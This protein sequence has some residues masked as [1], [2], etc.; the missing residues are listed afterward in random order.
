MDS[1]KN[2]AGRSVLITGASTG[3]GAC[4]AVALAARGARVTVAAR[5]RPELEETV[6][7]CVAAGGEAQAVPADV[8]DAASCRTLV[9]AAVSRFGG[10]DALVNN[11]GISMWA[12][13]DEVTDLSIY[14]KLMRVN[15]LGAVYMTHHALPHLKQSRGLIVAVS[16]LTGKTGVPTRTGY[17][18]SKHALQGFF[19][20]L[21]IELAPSGVDVLVV[22]PGF[23]ATDVRARA[24][25]A[26]GRPLGQSLRDETRATMPL[27]E[28]VR[29]IVAA[30]E[31]RRRELV[32][33]RMARVGLWLK[34]LAPSLVDRIAASSVRGR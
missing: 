30:M 9:E 23:V 34:L 13:F 27:D 2:W 1:L 3:I 22:S 8:A 32:M 20:S 12:R 6:R 17:A 16:S 31:G 14:E 7:Q 11:A 18:A 33:T 5:R 26:D 19:D 4:L 28:C 21:R 29:Q 15:Y 25:G 10:L 24:F